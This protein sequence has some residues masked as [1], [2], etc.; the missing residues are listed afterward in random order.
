MRGQQERALELLE[1]CRK[2]GTLPSRAHLEKDKDMDSLRDLDAFKE[3]LEQAYPT[4]DTR[5]P[6]NTTKKNE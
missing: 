6:D 4:E 5:Q 3:F 1:K 2:A